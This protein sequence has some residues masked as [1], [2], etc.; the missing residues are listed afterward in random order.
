MYLE[1]RFIR[2]IL[3]GIVLYLI[4]LLA[5]NY[6]YI[7][8]SKINRLKAMSLFESNFPFEV[9]EEPRRHS[10]VEYPGGM[11]FSD[12]QFN[13]SSEFKD[14]VLKYEVVKVARIT[15]S[16]MTK[17]EYSVRVSKKFNPDSSSTYLVEYIHYLRLAGQ[18]DGILQGARI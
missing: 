6:V 8:P 18:N 13:N 12:K 14:F 1:R 7:Q 5:Y 3:T 15:P 10:W 17:I 4:F 2:N 11:Q 16:R 9:V